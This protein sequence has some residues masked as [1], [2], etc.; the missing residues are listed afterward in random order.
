MADGR[1][2]TKLEQEGLER[3]AE[4]VG[5]R[6]HGGAAGSKGR[7]G[8]QDMEAETK[9]PP[10]MMPMKTSTPSIGSATDRGTTSVVETGLAD[11]S[12]QTEFGADK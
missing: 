10:A 2:L 9:D 11:S 4:L 12:G 3:T 5:A 8:V 6:R 7:C 1:R